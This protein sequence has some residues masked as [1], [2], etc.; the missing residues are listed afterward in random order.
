MEL[1]KSS[2]VLSSE[3]LKAAGEYASLLME[4]GSQRICEGDI[5]INP[6]SEKNL[7]AC[8]YCPYGNVCGFEYRMGYRFRNIKN[9]AKDELWEKIENKDTVF[10]T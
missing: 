10:S 1:T 7:N 3:R 5:S 9:Q 2:N 6:Y 8:F 4:R